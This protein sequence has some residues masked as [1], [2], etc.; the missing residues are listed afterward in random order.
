MCI[1]R[2]VLEKI[3]I[4]LEESGAGFCQNKYHE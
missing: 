3:A 4:F 1:V 2:V